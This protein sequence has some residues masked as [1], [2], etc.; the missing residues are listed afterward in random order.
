MGHSDIVKEQRKRGLVDERE[1]KKDT[2]RAAFAFD[3]SDFRG[4]AGGYLCRRAG[5]GRI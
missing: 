1:R 5:A 2:F 4:T 3:D